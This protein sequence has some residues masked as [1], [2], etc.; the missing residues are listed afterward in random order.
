MSKRMNRALR[1]LAYGTVLLGAVGVVFLATRTANA[2][3]AMAAEHAHGAKA[4]GGDSARAVT[5]TADQARRI[6][7]TYAVVTAGSLEKEVRT[8][9]QITYDET[10]VHTVAPKIDGW[11]EQLYVNATGQPVGVGQP[12]LTIYSPMLV[13]A[14]E[15]LLLAKQL[16]ADLAG[17]SADARR[18]AND[19]V[20][21]ARQRLDY[22]DIQPNE[23]ADVERTGRVRKTLTL[24]SAVHGFV[25][26]KK[27][28]AG[29]KI[30]A[31]DAL[32]T[33]ADLRTVWVEGEVFE[34]DLATVRVGLTVHADFEALPGEHRMG[35]IAY[36]YPTIDPD[37]RTTKVRVVL[38][39]NELRFK[40]G[41]YATLRIV[42]IRR[43]SALTVVRGA[44]LS[45]GQR[46][47]VFVR[48]AGGRLAPREVVVGATIGDRV[49]ILRG[50]SAGETVVASATFLVDAESNLG[51]ALGGMGNMPGM[52]V[53]TPPRPLPMNDTKQ[54]VPLPAP[55]PSGRRPPGK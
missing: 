55:A 1:G 44:V 47:I 46:H 5:L 39:N 54:G 20:M 25:L 29:Q 34:Q 22:W 37:T 41:M 30:M 12:L 38:P 2:P 26:D 7:V 21:S 50:L 17:G 33:V 48:E 36:I 15:E 14:Q 4:A 49:E 45:T 16:E 18:S 42:G 19:L 3:A 13:Q 35:R 10:S 28:L 40:P 8:I 52:E 11:V 43:P 32:F 9:G 24:R 51:T 31:G 6:G 53:T 23:I 27:V